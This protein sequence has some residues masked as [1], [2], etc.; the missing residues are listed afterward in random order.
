VKKQPKK[1][2]KDGELNRL[3]K[4]IKKLE[5]ENDRLK[6]ELNS[7]EQ[8][9]KKTTKF[10]RDNTEEISLENLIKAAKSEKS[11]K[12]VKEESTSNKCPVCSADIKIME[13]LV[14]KI[15]TCTKCSYRNLE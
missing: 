7:Y 6:S 15:I 14:G 11:L 13:T 10:L 3:K 2:Y 12:E 8:A 5:K 1:E 4:R 9:F